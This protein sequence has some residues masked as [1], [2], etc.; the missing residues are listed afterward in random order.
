MYLSLRFKLHIILVREVLVLLFFLVV[1]MLLLLGG[2]AFLPIFIS[3]FHRVIIAIAIAAAVVPIHCDHRRRGSRRGT[4]RK[5]DG[6][7]HRQRQPLVVVSVLLLHPAS[8]AASATDA[9]HCD[10]TC[11]HCHHHLGL[12]LQTNTKGIIFTC[13]LGFIFYF[14]LF[15]RFILFSL[16]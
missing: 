14:G 1:L 3:I 12:D 9:R 2:D 8:L 5:R 10:Q 11:E 7:L 13:V 6:R 16:K 4:G 15:T